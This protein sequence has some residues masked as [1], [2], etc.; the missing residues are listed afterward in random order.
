MT[1]E[2]TDQ[3]LVERQKGRVRGAVRWREIED[4]LRADIV[5]GRL[6]SGARLPPEPELMRRFGVGRHTLRQAMAALE[7]GGLVRIEQGRGTFVHDGAIRYRISRRT[8]FSQNL[9]EQGRD[10]GL[11]ERHATEIRAS[12]DVR[13]AL[14]L[15]QGAMVVEI[16]TLNS[17][18]GV[19][20][21]LGR[22]YY[23]A[24]RFPGFAQRCL[25]HAT[26][27]A[28]YADYGIADYV[29]RS[30]RVEARLPTD[31]EARRLQ[32]P[33]SLPVLVTRKVD[34]DLAGTPIGYSATVWSAERIVFE[35]DPRGEQGE[36][37]Q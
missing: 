9:I 10:P 20:L 22:S 3:A 5:D 37:H 11:I 16:V 31:E 27:S 23:P 36:P 35:F 4:A 25:K 8:R 13:R 19:P 7:R 17:A 28:A 26:V 15:P 1:D 2:A 6:E 21:G 14:A 30:T 33:R 12:E 32:Q 34:T 24:A 29:R 18:D